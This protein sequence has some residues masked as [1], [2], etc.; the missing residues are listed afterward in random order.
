MKCWFSGLDLEFG[1]QKVR[2]RGKE[3]WYLWAGARPETW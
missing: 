3:G 1:N 2:T